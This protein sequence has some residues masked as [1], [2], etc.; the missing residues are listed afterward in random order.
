MPNNAPVDS[1][2]ARERR[3]ATGN[4][5]L[6]TTATEYD[7]VR[8]AV[9]YYAAVSGREAAELLAAALNAMPRGGYS[10]A[11]KTEAP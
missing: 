6:I 1:A 4:V 7:L 3:E 10:P 11:A 9:G 2:D 8:G 5:T